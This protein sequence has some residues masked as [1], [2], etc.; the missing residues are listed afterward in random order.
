MN[1]LIISLSWDFPVVSPVPQHYSFRQLRL[2]NPACN[3]SGWTPFSSSSFLA[4]SLRPFLVAKFPWFKSS[5]LWPSCMLSLHNSIQPKPTDA[6]LIVDMQDQHVSHEYSSADSSPIR[7]PIRESKVNAYFCCN[8]YIISLNII[9]RAHW[10]MLTFEF[11]F[12]ISIP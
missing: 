6:T 5:S 12:G 2:L 10:S 4:V 8:P 11:F 3:N 1:L 7:K 9:Y